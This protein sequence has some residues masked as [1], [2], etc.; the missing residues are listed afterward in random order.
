MTS[1]SIL[2]KSAQ[3]FAAQA[4]PAATLA[5]VLVSPA[6][7]QPL[8]Q[9]G[10]LE[11]SAPEN[12][13]C[14]GRPGPKDGFHFEAQWQNVATY[15][16]QP[17][18]VALDHSCNLYVANK[19]SN[20]I[21]KYNAD[22]QQ[23]AVWTMAARAD[24]ADGVAAVAVA[25]D[26]TLY[27]ADQQLS[28]VHKLSPTGQEVGTWKGCDCPGEQGWMVSPV[29]VAV[30]GTGNNVYVLDRSADT[31]TRYS[32][33]GKIQKV[34]GSQGTGPGQF[35]VPAS[36]TLDRVGN[37]YVADWGNHRI[38]KFS[39]DGA[40]LGQFGT[41]GNGPGQ[42]HLP[43]GVTV[44]RDGNMYVSDSDNW[45]MI[46]FAPDGT[47]ADQIP[48]CAAPGE[49]NVLDGT[50]PGQFFDHNGVVVD[51]QGNLYVADSGN[52]RVE[53]RVVTEVANPPAAG[54]D[55]TGD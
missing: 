55:A 26:G 34:F 21:F 14:P 5:F 6:A 2:G 52:D 27:V 22:G 49:C 35:D 46:K 20:Q 4:L 48:A 38:Q 10:G 9:A 44:D 16:G 19:T 39:P 8:A 15:S 50:D 33:D 18:E 53:R 11:P 28:Q 17:F 40:A 12:L 36:I 30:D 47:P 29:S 41:D 43:S 42:I 54:A 23:V 7:A 25:P 45:R 3:R 37:V 13:R 32:P 1:F 31:V 24:G 51:G